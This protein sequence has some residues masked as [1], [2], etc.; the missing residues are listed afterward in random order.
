[1][2]ELKNI[3]DEGGPINPKEGISVFAGIEGRGG[4]KINFPSHTTDGDDS[5]A[6]D[7]KTRQQKG[8]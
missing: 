7:P 8:L 5:S 2:A 1:M 3:K 6:A 4:M